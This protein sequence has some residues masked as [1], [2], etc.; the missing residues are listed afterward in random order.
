MTNQLKFTGGHDTG[1][2]VYHFGARYYDPEMARWIQIDPI[3]QGADLREG[4]RYAYAAADPTNLVDPYGLFSV[5]KC[6]IG[7]AAGAYEAKGKPWETALGA[8][9]GCFSGGTNRTPPRSGKKDCTL[10]KD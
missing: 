5:K 4:N 10:Y 7:G 8:A 9:A 1:Q 3:D 6:L 2:G